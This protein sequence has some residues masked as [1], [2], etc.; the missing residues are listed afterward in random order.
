MFLLIGLGLGLIVFPICLFLYI[1]ISNAIMRRKIKRIM[2][3]EQFLTPI[4]PKDYDVKAWQNK[5]YGNIDIEAQKEILKNLNLRIFKITDAP[6]ES[7]THQ[8]F[9]SSNDVSDIKNAVSEKIEKIEKIEST[10]N[11]ENK[12]SEGI[13][14]QAREYLNR[15]RKLGYSDALI[16]SEFKK[17]NYT[18]EVI[19]KIFA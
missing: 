18:E 8:T 5:K 12:I 16:R 14:I 6:Q 9:Q 4:D 13:I 7:Q 11:K 19:N 1:K 2:K 3:K 15:A 17:K 10:E